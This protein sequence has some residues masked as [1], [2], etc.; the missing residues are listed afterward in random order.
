MKKKYLAITLT[1]LMIFT[2]LIGCG[3]VKSA[4]MNYDSNSTGSALA[5]GY[6]YDKSESLAPMEPSPEMPVKPVDPEGALNDSV[7][8]GPGGTPQTQTSEKI[9][10][11][12]YVNL[13]T[14]NFNETVTT[15]EQTVA[16]FGGFIESSDHSGDTSYDAEGNVS[17]LNRRAY[18]T[19]RIPAEK[20]QQFLDLTG[21]LGNVISSNRNAQNVTSQYTDYEARLN[22][23][24]IQEQRLLAMMEQT[25][26]IDALIKLESKLSDVRYQIESYQRSLNNLDAR[27]TYSSVDFTIREVRVYKTTVPVQRSFWQRMSD[28]FAAGWNSFV[29]GVQDFFLMLAGSVFSLL[30]FAVF[31]VVAIIII[32]K[33]RKKYMKKAKNEAEND[34]G[35][36]K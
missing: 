2:L 17:I 11:S 28:S 12:A 4:S 5:P 23:L 7:T 26:D 1:V 9:I 13:E 35:D 34:A 27:I 22:S 15:L 33:L 24:K 29:E 18:Y 25:K 10:Y 31:V 32:I 6:D 8:D 3:S 20:F 36:G 19:V 30:L 21:T 16:S 14:L